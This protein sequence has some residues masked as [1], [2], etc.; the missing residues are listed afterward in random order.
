MGY[1]NAEG[2]IPAD[3]KLSNGI[4]TVDDPLRSGVSMWDGGEFRPWG[5]S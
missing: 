2:V 4:E 1:L 3:G 5:L